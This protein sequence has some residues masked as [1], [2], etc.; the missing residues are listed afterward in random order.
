[1]RLSVCLSLSPLD[2]TSADKSYGTHVEARPARP[3]KTRCHILEDRR[4]RVISHYISYR[5]VTSR[6]MPVQNEGLNLG[7]SRVRSSLISREQ[8]TSADA[9]PTMRMMLKMKMKKRRR[10]YLM[11]LWRTERLGG[12]LERL[13]LPL[14][15]VL[16]YLISLS[17]ESRCCSVICLR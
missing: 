7:E 13:L 5:P 1:M 2:A 10:R 15:R 8:H 12:R 14:L 11:R 17:F 4:T 9:A 3:E 16:L 6:G